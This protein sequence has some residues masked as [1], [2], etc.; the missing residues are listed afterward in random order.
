LGRFAA[1]N[2][3]VAQAWVGELNGEYL[4]WARQTHELQFNEIIAKALNIS[5]AKYTH[6]A[7]G[8][9]HQ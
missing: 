4:A 9:N 7:I 3:A 5:L 6:G 8:Q 1:D 2:C